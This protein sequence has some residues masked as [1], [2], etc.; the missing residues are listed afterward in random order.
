[1]TTCYVAVEPPISEISNFAALP[2]VGVCVCPGIMAIFQG[3][4]NMF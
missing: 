2:R 4:S 1:M 3:Q